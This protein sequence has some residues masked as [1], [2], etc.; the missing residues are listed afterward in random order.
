MSGMRVLDIDD[1]GRLL[2]AVTDGDRRRLVEAG[3]KGAAGELTAATDLTAARYLPGERKVVVQH[4][5]PG[6]LS[7]LKIGGRLRPLVGSPTH[8]TEL[9]AVLPGRIVYRTNRKHRLLYTVAIRNVLVGEEVAVYDRGG[10]VLEAAVS[11][12]SRYIAIRLPRK[13][14]LVDTMP[15]TEDDHVR[16]ISPEPAERGRRNLRWLPDSTRLVATEYEADTA[17]VVRYDVA[18]ESWH[19]VVVSLAADTTGW[20][21]PD[22]RRVAVASANRLAFHQ[23]ENGRFL[24]AAELP[25]EITEDGF[26]WSPDSRAVAATTATGEIV[27]VT[28]DSAGVETVSA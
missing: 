20:V 12:N 4:G 3:G 24:R 5:D 9:L 8:A 14:V 17:R 27:R 15:V 21:A 2:I 22:G 18:S 13:L 23:T 28:A 19:P 16:L 11:P 1:Q 25:A 7:L 10:A 26:L 6:Q